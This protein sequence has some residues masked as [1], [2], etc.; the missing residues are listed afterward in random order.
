M[1]AEDSRADSVTADR[2]ASDTDSEEPSRDP[3]WFKRA[4][5]YE[6]LIRGFADSNGD[7]TGDLRGVT[8]KLDYL[9]WLGIDCV[10]LLP[11]YDSPLRDGGY[12]IA[13]YFRILPEFG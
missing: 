7:G 10:W 3:L 11:I 4:V 2:A 9:S 12:D 8:G 13:D 1:S 6:V 5:F